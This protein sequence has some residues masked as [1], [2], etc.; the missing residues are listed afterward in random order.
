MKE[1]GWIRLFGEMV[2]VI[3]TVL[4]PTG[5]GGYIWYDNRHSAIAYCK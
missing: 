3:V 5:S 4:S 1:L 2:F